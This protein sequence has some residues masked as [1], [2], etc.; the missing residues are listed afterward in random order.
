MGEAGKARLG[1]RWEH[2][3]PI[4]SHLAGM[5]LT[6]SMWISLRLETLWILGWIGFS[7]CRK[8]VELGWTWIPAGG[9]GETEARRI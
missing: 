9:A 3:D 4:R 1:L 8:C 7:S 5:G 6:W 2:P